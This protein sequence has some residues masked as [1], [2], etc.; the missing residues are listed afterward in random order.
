MTRGQLLF[1]CLASLQARK[2][3]GRIES[4]TWPSIWG[5]RSR[6][7]NNRE[8]RPRIKKETYTAAQIMNLQRTVV[9][10]YYCFLVVLLLR[11][12]GQSRQ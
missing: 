1:L 12:V 6:D 9:F 8:G 5:K 2:T 4:T 3:I 11:F 10:Y 7:D